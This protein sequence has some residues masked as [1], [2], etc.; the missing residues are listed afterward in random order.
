MI[1]ASS[2][3]NVK[4]T[5]P[6]QQ[7]PWGLVTSQV[8][9]PALIWALIWSMTVLLPVVSISA[10]I[11]LRRPAEAV[12]NRRS[13]IVR[14]LDPKSHGQILLAEQS[15]PR[16]EVDH[17]A[18]FRSAETEFLLR[19]DARAV[20]RFRQGAHCDSLDR[21]AQSS[22]LG[23]FRWPTGGRRM[24]FAAGIPLCLLRSRGWL[25]WRA[26]GSAHSSSRTGNSAGGHV[27]NYRLKNRRIETRG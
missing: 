22:T 15:L 2:F 12:A 27:E 14:F 10:R 21:F 6:R 24:E 8:Q 26:A 19:R 18:A 20:L 3:F 23:A 9:L 7:E 17:I 4:P 1:L 13:W 16:S 11:F 5:F 25:R